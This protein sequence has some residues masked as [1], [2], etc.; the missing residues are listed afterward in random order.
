V[1]EHR[2]NTFGGPRTRILYRVQEII[3]YLETHALSKNFGNLRALSEVDLAIANKQIYGIAG[4]NGAGK[5]TLFNVVAGLYSP[6]SGKV[7]FE[8]DNITGWPPHRICHKGIGR[9]FQIPTAFHSISVRRNLESGMIFGGG[10]RE[11][12]TEVIELLGLE[13]KL[14]L[15][16]ENLDLWTTKLVMLGTVLTTGCKLLMLDEPMAG[17]SVHEI[18]RFV[19]LVRN[20]NKSFG[21][22]ILI[23]EHLLDV[24]VEL[25]EKLLILDNGRVIAVGDPSEVIKD[26]RVIESYLGGF[27]EKEDAFS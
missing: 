21:T 22:T 23:I 11:F 7:L 27:E 25:V 1:R 9:T 6:S 2:S 13:S 8:G 16:A 10:S 5:S 20:I 14:D 24:L 18:Q 17:F 12:L 19:E 4:P 15:P 3:V 26:K